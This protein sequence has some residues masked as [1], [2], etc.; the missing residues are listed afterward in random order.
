MIKTVINLV[1][2]AF[3]MT[4]CNLLN[5]EIDG[6]KINVNDSTKVYTFKD[7]GKT[8][9]GTVVFYELDPKTGKNYKKSVRELKD[10]KRINKRYDYYPSGS[11]L[12]EYPYGD[13]GL[14]NGTVKI[15]HKNGKLGLISEYKNNK[16]N[17][18]TKGYKDSGIQSKE[19]IYEDGVKVKEYDFD[20]SGEKIIPAIEKLELVE[21]K[22][23]FYEYI[24]YNH[25]QI[26]YQPMVI[27]K[28]KNKFDQ[29]IT[30]TIELEGV[31][32]DN[33]KGEELSKASDYFQ[34]YSDSPLQAGIARQSSLQSS[35]GYTNASGIYGADI[36]CQILVNKQLFKTVN[37]NNDFLTSNRIQ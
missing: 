5:S 27:M 23:G 37:I 19:T 4:G 18:V 1:G 2:I 7:D 13:N 31:F 16:Q 9:T 28:W 10:G 24:D 26:L 30:Q 12:S 14:T 32:I 35:V 25:N 20:E 33:K 22:T 6:E 34:G 36:S 8:V 21:F 29:A 17:G 11:I 3:L 15:F